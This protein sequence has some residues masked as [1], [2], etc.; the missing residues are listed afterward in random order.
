M[1][2]IVVTELNMVARL[3]RSGMLKYFS[4]EELS[5]YI[6]DFCYNHRSPN[7]INDRQIAKKLVEDGILQ[8]VKLSESQMLLVDKWHNY[9]RPKFVVKSITALVFAGDKKFKLFS[10]C[11]LLRETAAADFG[12]R[13]INKEW[14]VMTLVNDISVMGEKLD[15][16]L[17]RQLL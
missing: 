11:E 14:L 9:Y 17:V 3:Y 7:F 12:V 6:T 5:F 1:N 10:D 2:N 16:E 4:G 8:V 13:S 15:M